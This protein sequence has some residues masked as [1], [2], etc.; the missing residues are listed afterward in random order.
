MGIDVSDLARRSLLQIAAGLTVAGTLGMTTA[1]RA[2]AVPPAA[3]GKPGDFDFLT[4]EWTIEHRQWKNDRWDR[5]RGEATVVG[6]LGGIASVEEL[7]IPERDFSGLGLR[8]LD[9]QRKLWA[10]YWVNR[11]S[12]VLG[13]EPAWGSFT[14]GVGTWDGDD[15]DANGKPILV[16]GCWDR[17]TPISC[18]WYQATSSDD[19]KTWKENWVMDWARRAR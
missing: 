8:L 4:G 14:D 6:L 11:R 1:A 17:I 9:V 16:R 10:D 12:G 18:R 13:A 7:R 15:T 2:A 3:T 19:G 5:F